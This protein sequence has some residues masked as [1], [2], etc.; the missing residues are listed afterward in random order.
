[1]IA[2]LSSFADQF[3]AELI[4]AGKALFEKGAIENLTQV[5]GNW[6][7]TVADSKSYKVTVNEEDGFATIVFC[8][9]GPA[10]CRHVIGVFY[11]LQKQLNIQPETFNPSSL[12]PKPAVLLGRR[13]NDLIYTSRAAGSKNGELEKQGNT[14]KLAEKPDMARL[15]RMVTQKLMWPHEK[16]QYPIL[17]GAQ[18][19]LGQA[20]HK[21][22]E[23]DFAYAFV[24]A[25]AVLTEICGGEHI[26]SYS[27]SGGE[28]A[29][30]AV[31]ILNTL[32]T[33]PEVPIDLRKEVIGRVVFAC[34]KELYE[35]YH[36]ELQAILTNPALDP[37]L[38][39]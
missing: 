11:A 27:Y 17:M 13:L 6:Y 23:K 3:D 14:I 19:L 5:N 16:S 12:A 39:N 7:A 28:C 26:I 20:I 2:K 33:D 31:E 29:K 15:K 21:Y 24:I 38:K 8:P 32:C 1:M 10:M 35:S 30:A 25:K 34:E 9:C 36:K 22:A 4:E 18:G 37:D